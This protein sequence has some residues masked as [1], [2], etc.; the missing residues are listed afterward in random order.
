MVTAACSCMPKP[1]ASI[2]EAG[3]AAQGEGPTARSGR[4][5]WT[6]AKSTSCVTVS[7]EKWERC[8]GR[9]NHQCMSVMSA[10]LMAALIAA[11]T[12][13]APAGG[14]NTQ[15]VFAPSAS[16]EDTVFLKSGG[17]VRGRVEA[18][19][20]GGQVVLRQP[21]GSLRTFEGPEV[22]RVEVAGAAEPVVEPVAVDDAP[23]AP[24]PSPAPGVPQAAAQENE[25]PLAPKSRDG[26]ARV[27]LVRVDGGDGEPVLFKRTASMGDRIGRV[28]GGGAVG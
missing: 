22:E 11:P 6:Q 9:G 1:R 17:L 28:R 12:A 14:S 27:H 18:Y 4:P 2:G 25:N 3:D 20:P 24:T 10:A 5:S 13:E 7:G 21:D 19:E 8:A 16:A 23:P 26:A 15:E